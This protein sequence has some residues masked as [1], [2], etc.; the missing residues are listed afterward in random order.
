MPDFASFELFG[1]GIRIESPSEDLWKLLSW[2]LPPIELVDRSTWDRRYA[3]EREPA[4][5]SLLVHMDRRKVVRAADNP[6]AAQLIATDL[7]RFLARRAEGL[8]FVHAGA[9]AWK[10]R[11]ILM[12]GRSGSGKSELVA[13]L[14]REGAELLSDELA[15][16]D[17]Q[18]LVHPYAR[19]LALR[20]GGTEHV[21][22]ER[23]GARRARSASPAALL[24]FLRYAPGSRWDPAPLP[25]GEALLGLLGFSLAGRRRFD[26]VRRV[27]HPLA[28]SVPALGG[29][30]GQAA[31]A[32][33]E[34]LAVVDRTL[35]A[36]RTNQ[37]DRAG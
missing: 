9:V 7:E 15:V 27:L 30:R 12:P 36:E 23:L 21:E 5:G 26:L 33:R 31:E 8:V 24:A 2:R 4:D 28:A 29:S 3:V 11:A 10:G 16:I 37:A 13:A 6:A 1:L 34:L 18:G 25:R 19:P 22:P 20:R 32:A 35:G 17:V 14:L